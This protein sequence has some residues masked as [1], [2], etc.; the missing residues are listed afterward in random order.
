MKNNSVIMYLHLH[1][2]IA[3]SVSIV[4]KECIVRLIKAIT[5]VDRIPCLYFWF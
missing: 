2:C 5:L 4:N 3:R 1:L